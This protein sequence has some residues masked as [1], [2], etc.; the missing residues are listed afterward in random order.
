[1]PG[2]KPGRVMLIGIGPGQADWRT[3]EASRLIQSADELV[4]TLDE[5]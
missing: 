5:P 1:L 3:P 4:G 2:R